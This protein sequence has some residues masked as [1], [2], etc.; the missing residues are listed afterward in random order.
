MS[1]G[2]RSWWQGSLG[3]GGARRL[4]RRGVYRSTIEREKDDS[5]SG[6]TKHDH[7]HYHE[8]RHGG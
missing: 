1:F 6:S 4:E 3:L 5:R 8:V 2:L 7:E